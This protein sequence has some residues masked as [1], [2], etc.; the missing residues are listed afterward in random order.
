M[1]QHRTSNNGTIPL[2]KGLWWHSPEA[3]VEL[4]CP[5]PVLGPIP[6]L[7]LPTQTVVCRRRPH[8]HLRS[9]TEHLYTQTQGAHRRGYE[10]VRDGGTEGKEQAETWAHLQILILALTTSTVP[11][12]CIG[13]L[14]LV[15]FMSLQHDLVCVPVGWR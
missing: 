7:A 13:T 11:R 14:I 15:S 1:D 8:H 4:E 6:P 9:R 5:C 2:N 12:S 10:A 3:P